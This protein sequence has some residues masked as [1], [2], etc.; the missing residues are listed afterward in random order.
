[1]F[2]L[3]PDLTPRDSHSIWYTSSRNPVTQAALLEA[4]DQRENINNNNN[5]HGGPSQ[6]QQQQH[7]SSSRRAGHLL[8]ER[9]ALARLRVDEQQMDRRRLHVQNFGST[10]LKPPGVPKSLHQIREELR[11]Q[12]EHAEA[13]RREQLAQEL[14]DAEAAGQDGLEDIVEGE[15]GEEPR[16]LDDEIPDAE[17]SFGFDGGEDSMADELSSSEGGILDNGGGGGSNSSDDDEDDDDDDDDDDDA[18]AVDEDEGERRD[19]LVAAR[20]RMADDAFRQAMARG[21]VDGD[22]MYGAEEELEASGQGDMLDEEDLLAPGQ[23]VGADDDLGMDMDADLDDEIPEARDLSGVYE[24]TDSEAESSMVSSSD[25]RGATDEE[26][27]DD[28][29]V[30][31]ISFAPRAAP[32]R[33]PLSPTGDRGRGLRFAA[34]P[35]SSLDLSGLLSADGSSMMD[36]S[37]NVRAHRR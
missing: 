21:D 17:E 1:M 34:A 23:G 8:I 14:A 26:D 18:T 36:S 3:L 9:S 11:E 29:E 13:M 24:H 6:Q 4:H 10:W 7:S 25:A 30:G 28:D 5:N 37:P 35:R 15:E 22:D 16:D 12:Q 19:V 2:G 27:D 20:M 31:D 33:A 32:L